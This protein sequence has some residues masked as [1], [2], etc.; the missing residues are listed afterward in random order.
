[1]RPTVAT[2]QR[3]CALVLVT[4][5]AGT[6]AFTARAAADDAGAQASAGDPRASDANDAI[7]AIVA[8]GFDEA[9]GFATVLPE[10]AAARDAATLTATA[11]DTLPL[12]WS[13]FTARV[14]PQIAFGQP[15]GE[16]LRVGVEQA[17][18]LTSRRSA[19]RAALIAESRQR[20]AEAA[21][22]A[23]DARLE[24]AK[25]W[26]DS[27]AA[28]A[29]LLD[30]RRARELARE[31]VSVTERAAAAGEAT[32]PELADARALLASA[33]TAVLDAEGR[34]RDASFRLGAAAGAP[35][36]RRASAVLP[37]VVLP[38]GTAL[39][40]RLERM[41][42]MPAVRARRVAA[43][44]ARA[45]AA[46]VRA[47][48]APELLAGGE[49]TLDPGGDHRIA[50]TIGVALPAFDRGER[51]RAQLE[52]EA[53]RIEGEATAVARRARFE[54][55]QAIHDVEHTGE[56]AAEIEHGLVP[57]VDD[58]AAKRRR[59]YE[60]GESTVIEVLSAERTSIA[61]HQAAI[62]A[63]ADHAWARVR[64]RILLDA[65]DP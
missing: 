14:M 49:L 40:T 9:T 27:W 8:I 29:M 20:A 1:M 6:G 47:W 32:A 60:L 51:E 35:G 37:E 55:A 61:G 3:R 26:I 39:A 2:M 5:V 41:E 64:V 15:R 62:A 63:R 44:A 30:A 53:R 21:A 19:A 43:L 23:L 18:P 48:R 52:A 22:L 28:D 33:E 34:A 12:G 57:A 13:P 54:L 56:L 17:I 38:D 4:V 58:A 36:P 10:V 25:A 45:R 11:S 7:D 24:I 50:A 42:A 59:A 65:G 46:E 31:I 16:G